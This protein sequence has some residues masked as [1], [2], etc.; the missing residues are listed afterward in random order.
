VPSVRI[1]QRLDLWIL[2]WSV[3]DDAVREPVAVGDGLQ[4]GRLRQRQVSGNLALHVDR[5]DERLVGGVSK[6]VVRQIAAGDRRVRI[7]QARVLVQL[8]V[9]QV[10]VGVDKRDLRRFG[11]SET[12]S[13]WR[14]RRRCRT[15]RPS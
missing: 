13:T 12:V 4:P 9:P 1:E 5:L 6:E 8:G 15:L 10:V 11:R 7:G 14:G 3:G 2:Q